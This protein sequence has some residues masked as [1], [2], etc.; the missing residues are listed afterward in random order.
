MQDT[1]LRCRF[2]RI[3]A[4]EKCTSGTHKSWPS[5]S[6]YFY[7]SRGHDSCDPLVLQTWWSLKVSLWLV[8]CGSLHL[9]AWIYQRGGGC[10]T[11]GA[12]ILFPKF[13]RKLQCIWWSK[14]QNG[15]LVS[16]SI[17]RSLAPLCLT[18]DD[19][20]HKEKMEQFRFCGMQIILRFN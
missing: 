16:P 4:A 14:K 10:K 13:L 18:T 15:C 17:S 2:A 5:A 1:S 8:P 19:W 20:L 3:D 6:M 9:E 12:A 11:M 7:G